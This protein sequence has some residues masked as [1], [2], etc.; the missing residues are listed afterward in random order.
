MGVRWGIVA[1]ASASLLLAAC[2]SEPG[3]VDREIAGHRLEITEGIVLVAD[4]VGVDVERVVEESVEEVASRLGGD[5]AIE[6]RV[7]TEYVI[8][9]FGV[10]GF[11]RPDTGTVLVTLDRRK[12]SDLSRTLREALPSLL[13][14]ELHHSK[15]IRE[16]PGYGRR[17][18][19]AM[20]TEGAGDAF[21]LEV[22][23]DS[24]L[25]WTEALSPS[26]E[27]EM[28]ERAQ[29]ELTS[30]E[31]DHRSWFFGGDGIPPWT[32]YTIGFRIVRAYLD[33]HPET[34]AADL[35][36]VPAP[37]VLRASGYEPAGP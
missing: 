13:A 19:E 11:T 6:L 34:S 20:V 14:H 32:G 8:P 36:T 3:P 23:E 10:G 7:G 16:G 4:E 31:Y 30:P 17:L 5:G 29:D 28:W 35:A 24:F 26:D 37:E 12:S 1:A 9:G 27:A 25:P 22:F 2:S 21:A 33:A 18:V 15:R